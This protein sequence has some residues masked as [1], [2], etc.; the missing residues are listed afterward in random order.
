MIRAVIVPESRNEVF[1]ITYGGG[2]TLKELAE[3]VLSEFPGIELKYNPRDS[4][5]P[6]R[7]TLSIEKARR[8]LGYE[9][10]FPIE[11]GFVNYIQWYREFQQAQPQ[12]FKS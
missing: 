2:R 12:L 3:L 10:N 9:P 5:M 8:I 11:K 6:E 1:N 7:G 4:L